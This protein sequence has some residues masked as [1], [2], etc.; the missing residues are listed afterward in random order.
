MRHQGGERIFCDTDFV[1][2]DAPGGGTFKNHKQ[3]SDHILSFWNSSDNPF[4]VFTGGEPLMHNLDQVVQKI[5][6]AGYQVHLETSGAYPLSGQW[7]WITLSP[8]KIKP[9][10][11]EIYPLASEL[12]VVVY[13]RHDFKWALTLYKPIIFN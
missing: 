2:T 7:K 4:I 6:S 11:D 13:N 10:L 3:L 12:K 1:G 9:P 8:K 5:S